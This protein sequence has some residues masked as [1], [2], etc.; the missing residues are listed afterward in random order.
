MDPEENWCG[1]K[2]VKKDR[3]GGK[4]SLLRVLQNDFI[5][6]QHYF[7]KRETQIIAAVTLV[8]TCIPCP[9]CHYIWPMCPWAEQ[10]FVVSWLLVILKAGDEVD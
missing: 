6:S 9:N 4:A 1:M 5:L 8:C 3:D 10:R 7:T 2:Q